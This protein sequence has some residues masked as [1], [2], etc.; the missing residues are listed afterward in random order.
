MGSDFEEKM[1]HPRHPQHPIIF[2]S[3]G[4]PFKCS[5]CVEEGYGPRYQCHETGCLFVLHDHCARARPRDG[6]RFHPFMKESLFEFLWEPP[7]TEERCCDACGQDIRGFLYRDQ[8]EN[9]FDLH[10][11]CM[12]LTD[13]TISDDGDEMML[14]LRCKVPSKCQM[15]EEGSK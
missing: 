3:E 10:P 6:P 14:N 1:N 7:G 5:G 13:I 8:S 4:D 2:K 15:Q 12:N 11:C 9:D